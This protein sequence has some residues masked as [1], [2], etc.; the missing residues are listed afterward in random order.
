MDKGLIVKFWADFPIP[1]QEEDIRFPYAN[2]SDA[3]KALIK[4]RNWS[5]TI[6]EALIEKS[7]SLKSSKSELFSLETK[8]ER[9]ER[10]IFVKNTPPGWAT[11]NKDTQ[12]AWIWSKA[13]EADLQLLQKM[14][15]SREVLRTQIFSLETDMG[16]YGLMLKTLEKTTEWLVQYINWQKHEVRM[17]NT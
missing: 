15:E 5:G 14:D 8:V 12:R 2:P 11:K 3:A 9:L 13:E 7:E 6:T 16:L 17:E 10:L 1:T 4:A